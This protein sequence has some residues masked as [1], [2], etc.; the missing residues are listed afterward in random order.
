MSSRTKFSVTYS[1][2]LRKIMNLYIS[3][4]V[5]E[6][7]LPNLPYRTYVHT[8]AGWHLVQ[9]SYGA[10]HGLKLPS[11]ERMKSDHIFRLHQRWLL[12]AGTFPATL[13]IHF[14]EELEID[15]IAR[16]LQKIIWNIQV[17]SLHLDLST[18]EFVGLS[19]LPQ[20]AF[21]NV[22]ELD[23][24]L[25][26]PD[27]AVVNMNNPSHLITKLRSVT[28][29]CDESGDWFD[30]LSP[31]LGWSQLRTLRFDMAIQDLYPI[32]VILRQIPILEELL[33]TERPLTLPS[34]RDFNL[35]AVG[36][37]E[38][39]D[40]G[41]DLDR[42]LRG[43]TCPSLTS[44]TLSTH[45]WAHWTGETFKLLGRQYNMSRLQ[46]VYYFSHFVL[47]ISSILQNMPMLRFLLAGPDIKLDDKAIIGISNG[48]LGRFIQTLTINV[49]GDFL[50]V[51]SMIEAR[52]RTVDESLEKGCSWRE[53]IALLKDITVITKRKKEYKRRVIALKK[54]GIIIKVFE[55]L[56]IIWNLARYA[57]ISTYTSCRIN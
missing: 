21:S 22:A 53:E 27:G 48:A 41:I 45:N 39:T 57:F 5:K 40:D 1:F 51:L 34:L 55:T 56:T 49:T 52:K 38:V 24:E 32:F 54:A 46:E 15:E 16:T 18:E 43:I 47:P 19:N 42:L 31:S 3:L 14:G 7:S 9:P 35:T 26:H 29:C 33:L 37:E 20:S 6:I 10:T 12:R 8:G 23:L 17:K 28:F 4:F 44:L 2:K 25:S 13:S 50:E 11:P 30:Q 36:T